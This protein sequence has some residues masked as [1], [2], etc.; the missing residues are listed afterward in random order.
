MAV[1]TVI[2]K[3]R[4]RERDLYTSH[5]SGGQGKPLCHRVVGNKG[6]GWLPAWGLVQ[7][8]SKSRESRNGNGS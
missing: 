5:L 1:L 4:E 2:Y 3:E 6:P 7:F 8:L